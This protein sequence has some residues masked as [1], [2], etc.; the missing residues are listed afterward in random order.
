MVFRRILFS[1]LAAGCAARAAAPPPALENAFLRVEVRANGGELT[2]VDKRTGHHWTQ[3]NTEADPARF[4]QRLS[5]IDLMAGVLRFACD[6]PA[7]TRSGQLESA[8]FQ[9]DLKLDAIR[10]EIAMIFQH[11]GQG[12]WRGV[13]YPFVFALDGDAARILYPHSG[14]MLVPVREDAVDFLKLPSHAFYGGTRAYEACVG[15]LESETGAGLL[16]L[17]DTMEPAFG[18]WP[19]VTLGTS[20]VIAP[21]LSW[22]AS[23]YH[24]DKPFRVQWSF[25][26]DGGYMAMAQ[27]YREWFAARG[28]HKTLDEKAKENPELE[29]LL[30]GLILWHCGSVSQVR[31]DVETLSKDHVERAL[32][33]L[34]SPP[35]MDAQGALVPEPGVPALVEQVKA[36]GYLIDRYDQYRDSF[37]WDADKSALVQ[38]NSDAFPQDII[39]REDGSLLSSYGPATGVINPQRALVY[40]RKRLPEALKRAAFNARFLDCVGSM[41]FDEGEDWSSEHPCDLYAT[42]A[43]REELVKYAHSLGPLL[44]AECGLDYTMPWIDWYEGP[45][46]LP[47][48]PAPASS[49]DEIKKAS[50]APPTS[51]AAWGVDLGTKYRVPFWALTHHDEAV[52]T[53]RWEDGMAGDAGR[54]RLSQWQRKNLWSVLYGAIP[55]YRLYHADF[56]QIH[57]GIAQTARYVGDWARKVGRDAMIA[58]RFVTRDHL[59][60]ETRF[61]SGVGVVV[62]FGDTPHRMPDGETI[63]PGSYRTFTGNDTRR[64]EA[65]PVPEM[66]YMTLRP[67]EK[68]APAP[69]P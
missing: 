20:R 53:W 6:A 58:H 47:G 26:S 12:E 31:E 48:F 8:H 21:Q 23:R 33:G 11:D 55:M 68:A 50:A 52:L 13:R 7:E 1:I 60:Q 44:G 62:N 35:R 28:L 34:P 39:H 46:T 37:A 25:I 61:S 36:L 22:R 43:A 17:Y 40:A 38:V 56:L 32:V 3:V 5:N 42:R 14:G 59:V 2:I 24:F 63:P 19:E 65:P 51:E 30:G 10:P 9:V 29:K 54:V 45:M 4:T 66:D 41:S 16:T 27:R 15:L 49:A 67:A 57:S 64:Y 69:A 18:R